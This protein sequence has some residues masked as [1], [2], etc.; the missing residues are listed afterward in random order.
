M[1]AAVETLS[2]KDEFNKDGYL[3]G[4]SAEGRDPGTIRYR[5]CRVLDHPIT[6]KLLAS[7]TLVASVGLALGNGK[8]KI[9]ITSAAV[10]AIGNRLSEI[11][12]PYGRDGADQMSGLITQYRTLTALIPDPQTSDDL[13]LRAVNVQA[14]LSYAVSGVSK[15]FGSSWVQGDALLN[16]LQTEAYGQGPAAAMLKKFPRLCRVITVGTVFWEAAF[17]VIYVLPRGRAQALLAAV[18]IFHVGVATTMELPRFVWGFFA[19]HGAVEYAIDTRGSRRT[20]EKVSFG[21]A[22]GLTLLSSRFAHEKR[23][24]AMQRRLGPK[25]TLRLQTPAGVV[26]YAVDRPKAGS[27]TSELTFVLE[28]GL[29]QP[30]EA[31]DWVVKQL[32]DD[33]T[34]IRYHRAGYGLTAAR[35][36]N[37]DLL[38]VLLDELHVTKRVVLVSH[39]IGSLFAASHLQDPRISDRVQ[40]IVLV[41]GTDPDLLENDRTNRERFGSFL[42]AQ[43][44]TLFAAVTGIYQWAPNAVERQAVYVP[45]IQFSHVQ[46][47]FSPRNIVNAVREYRDSVT[48]DALESLSLARKVLVIG[49]AENAEQ[50]KQFAKKIDAELEIVPNSTHRSIIGDDTHARALVDAVRRFTRD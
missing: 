3:R 15:A 19:A 7:A 23:E 13:F 43:A 8:R 11:R 31:W 30:L 40:G 42:Q 44:H 4:V 14:G 46:F 6:P 33:H 48:N 32:S 39:S 21:I 37:V 18:K 50:Q 47:V 38:S 26:E 45:D 12:T 49:S 5:L 20:F 34:V 28:C 35:S 1:L 27:N 29:G 36:S 10:I 9:Q 25:G 17:P 41:D 24:V 22:L 16:V 2:L